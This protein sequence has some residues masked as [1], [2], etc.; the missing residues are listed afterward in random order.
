MN[1]A[2]IDLNLLLAL[3]SLLEE[4]NVTRA[5][6]RLGVGQS[7]MSTN[8]ARLRRHYGDELLVRVGRGYELTPLAR[9]LLPQVRR[10]VPMMAEALGQTATFDPEVDQRSFTLS[11]SDFARVELHDR[12]G[13]VAELAPGVRLDLQPLPAQPIFGD[14]ELM[15]VDFV[16]ALPG[17]GF[18][19]ES[20]V[21]FT[22]TY[23][24]ILD[25]H[26]PYLQDG[27]LSWDDFVSCRRQGRPSD[28]H[29]TLQPSDGSANWDTYRPPRSAPTGCCRCRTWSP[30]PIW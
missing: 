15:A 6:V 27:V 10:T 20:E 3:Q 7:A 9:A 1:L 22:D 12:F 16:V 13:R 21:L 23:V 18:S 2:N 8:L 25:Q 29:T 11:M 26:N 28:V 19:G 17:I 24:C 5:G 14:R 30:V 4:S